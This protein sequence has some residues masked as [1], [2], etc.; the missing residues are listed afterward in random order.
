MPLHLVTIDIGNSFIM[1]KILVR[2]T[3][4]RLNLF[5]SSALTIQ[6]TTVLDPNICHQSVDA[7]NVF[8]HPAHLGRQHTPPTLSINACPLL[9]LVIVGSKMLGIATNKS[10]RKIQVIIKHIRKSQENRFVLGSL[11]VFCELLMSYRPKLV[12]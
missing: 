4:V 7:C 9:G 5:F 2:L 12:N 3:T 10:H 6:H 1:L 8:T 11:Y